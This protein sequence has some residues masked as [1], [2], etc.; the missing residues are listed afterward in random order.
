ML[1]NEKQR[2]TKDKK[3]E[4]INNKKKKKKNLHIGFWESKP[5]SPLLLANLGN[6][7]AIAPLIMPLSSEGKEKWK[8]VIMGDDHIGVKSELGLYLAEAVILPYIQM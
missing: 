4:K 2:Q 5:I 8:F 3:E 1:E 6:S 7:S